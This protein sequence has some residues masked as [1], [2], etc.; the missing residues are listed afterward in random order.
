MKLKK[1]K[2]LIALAVLG[3]ALMVLYMFLTKE[4]APEQPEV[5]VD[6]TITDPVAISYRL[7]D[8]AYDFSLGDG[9]WSC[10]QY[11]DVRIDGGFIQ[12]LVERIN[13]LE[14]RDRLDEVE[15]LATYGLDAS[16]NYIT[17]TQEDGTQ[18]TLTIG[19]QLPE[20]EAFYLIDGQ[21][22]GVAYVYN[23]ITDAVFTARMDF[24][25]YAKKNIEEIALFDTPKGFKEADVVSFDIAYGGDVY[26]MYP[27]ESGQWLAQ[28]SGEA[29]DIPS[30]RIEEALEAIHFLYPVELNRLTADEAYLEACGLTEPYMQVTVSFA[31]AEDLVI[32]VGE[33]GYIDQDDTY[34]AKR[35]TTFNGSSQV[36]LCYNQNV[37][38]VLHP[39]LEDLQ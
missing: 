33:Y 25:E 2:K 8:V 32:R 13:A 38:R 36:V 1:N 31:Q 6:T 15:S 12:G 5:T 27:S 34:N 26:H 35:Y 4:E 30:E 11:A 10:A 17:V 37:Q 21:L 24:V 7:D 20:D 28:R 18:L 14:I 16:D 39:I 29:Y 3:L 23:S 9:K 22:V 19:L